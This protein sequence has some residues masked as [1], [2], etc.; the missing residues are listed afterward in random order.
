MAGPC[1]WPVSFA[2]CSTCTPL[3]AMNVEEKALFEEAAVDYLWRWTDRVFGVC[4]VTIRPCR[5]QCAGSEVPSFWGKGPFPGGHLPYW[6]P[7]LIGGS[8]HNVLC[9]ACS[10]VCECEGGTYSL[11]L[12]GPVVS[13]T[14]V[15]VDGEELPHESYRV[16]NKGALVRVDGQVWPPCQDIRSPSTEPGTFEVTYQRGTE[17]PTGG[18]IAAGVLACELAKA[19]CNDASCALP[20]RVQ[21]I[22]RQ[23][24]TIA[25]LDAFD[26]V[27]AGHTGIWIIDSWVASV[28]KPRARSTVR[29]PDIP[30][31]RH[32]TTTSAAMLPPEVP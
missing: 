15:M 5:T 18:Q 7:V 32:R 30:W 13:V 23:G 4:D 25:V 3:D 21:S 11:R 17:V 20:Q 22:T 12:P 26:D 28:T 31:P 24:V 19:A 6:V 8:W 2:G 1:D 14:T 9:G 10:G 27:D 29:S 16:D